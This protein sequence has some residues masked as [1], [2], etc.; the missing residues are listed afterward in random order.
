MSTATASHGAPV[1]EDALDEALSFVAT[2]ATMRDQS[3]ARFPEDAV[4]ALELSGVPARPAIAAAAS[5]DHGAEWSLL[6]RIGVWGA[7][8]APGEGDP[9]RIVEGPDGPVMEGVK[10]FCSGAGGLDRALVTATVREGP[11]L[12]AYVDLTRDLEIDRRW[13]AGSGLRTS[14]S[15]RVVFRGAPVVPILGALRPLREI[16]LVD[17]IVA[18]DA[19]SRDGTAAIA[20]AHGARVFQESEVLSG[21]GPC[22]GK[23]EIVAYIDADTVDFDAGFVVGLLGPLIRDR[24]VSSASSR[25]P[26]PVRPP[27]AA[28]CSSA[29]RS[30]W[31]T[32]WRRQ[33]CSTRSRPSVSTGSSRWTSGR[34]RTATSRCGS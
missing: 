31:A 10:V 16:G 18:M 20:A 6:R 2:G 28:I 13:Y 23:G 32:G 1:G 8:P 14:E 9:A 22:R 30:R 34:A 24:S 3:P 19:A 33:C 21:F 12:L 29:R 11:P 7:D 5:W 27:R 17:E 26:W 15:H 25:S 4:R